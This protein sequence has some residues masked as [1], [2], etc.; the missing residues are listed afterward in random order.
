MTLEASAVQ[1]LDCVSGTYRTTA[2]RSGEVAFHNRCENFSISSSREDM[3]HESVEAFAV[4]G[5][6]SVSGTYRTNAPRSGEV[7]FHNPEKAVTFF[8]GARPRFVQAGTVKA[9]LITPRNDMALLQFADLSDN[10][11]IPSSDQLQPEIVRLE[12]E[13]FVAWPDRLKLD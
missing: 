7:A 4:Q 10:W 2:P 1:G 9:L 13:D 12:F 5:L 3:N 11:T 6:D 8:L